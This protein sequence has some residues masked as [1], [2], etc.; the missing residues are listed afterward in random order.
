M[1]QRLRF[2]RYIS[3][4]LQL[5]NCYTSESFAH[6]APYLSR[7]LEIF[8]THISE[9]TSRRPRSSVRKTALP[10]RLSSRR[11]TAGPPRSLLGGL[12]LCLRGHL[13][14]G[15]LRGLRDSASEDHCPAPEVFLS[16]DVYSALEEGPRR[17][18]VESPSFPPRR[19]TSLP[20]RSVLRRC[21]S[22]VTRDPVN[23]TAEVQ[24]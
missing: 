3:I 1:L 16:E 23:R 10:P 11:R 12:L 5:P 8:V 18:S 14:G 19:T 9:T 24:L 21:S 6:R 2:R 22:S 15:R 4:I 7:R 20:P 17:T 13:L